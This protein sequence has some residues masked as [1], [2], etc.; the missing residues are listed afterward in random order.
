MN[1]EVTGANGFQ[2]VSAKGDVFFSIADEFKAT[3]LEQLE[4]GCS[5]II[6]D[7]SKSGI[8][9]SSGIGAIVAAM[10]GAKAKKIRII[11]AGCNQTV[12]KVFQMIGFDQ[13]FTVT[14]TLDEALKA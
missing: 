2:I 13:H 3:I 10:P 8:I 5:T 11:L 1:F 7:F 12:R 9:D 6:L 14:S 4:S